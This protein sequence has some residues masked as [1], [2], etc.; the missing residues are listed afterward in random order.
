LDASGLLYLAETAS[1]AAVS[2]VDDELSLPEEAAGFELTE[3][4][5]EALKRL[6]L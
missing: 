3:E 5:R 2:L 4:Q 6:G 1:Q